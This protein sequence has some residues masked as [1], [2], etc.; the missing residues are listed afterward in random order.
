MKAS[1]CGDK[2]MAGV[3]LCV[4]FKTKDV[5]KRGPPQTKASVFRFNCSVNTHGKEM[6]VQFGHSASKGFAIIDISF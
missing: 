3:L 1:A 6:E 4:S 2:P 5:N